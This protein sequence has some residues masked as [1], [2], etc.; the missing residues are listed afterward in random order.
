MW[1]G[2]RNSEQPRFNDNDRIEVKKTHLF[3]CARHRKANISSK[4]TNGT[5]L[6]AMSTT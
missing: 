5:S 6:V 3:R 4:F 1:K 2:T